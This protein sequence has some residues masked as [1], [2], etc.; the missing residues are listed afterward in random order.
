M[1]ADAVHRA[2]P[3]ERLRNG[4]EMAAEIPCAGRVA[5]P[6]IQVVMPVGMNTG[7]AL[8]NTDVPVA[9]DVDTSPS[10]LTPKSG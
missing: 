1:G 7:L 4:C 9:N 3:A 6:T 10:S 2:I 5:N 8:H